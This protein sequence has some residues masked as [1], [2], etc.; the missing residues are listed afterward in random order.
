MA[1]ENIPESYMKNQESIPD[2]F[3]YDFKMTEDIIKTKVNLNR[4][5]FSFLQTGKKQVHFADTSVLV[6][7]SQS[8]LLKKGNCLWSELLDTEETY[9]CKLFFFSEKRLKEF[10]QKHIKENQEHKEAISYFVIE[11]DSYFDSYL[12]SLSTIMDAPVGFMDTL[13]TVKFEEL[14]LYLINKYGVKFENYL[15][16]LITEE[17][18]P[19]KK[20]V[21]KNVYT[22]LTLEEI[23]F[24]CNMS[25][26]TFKRHFI[27]EFEVSPGRW[28]RDKRLLKAKELILREGLKSSEVYFDL[29]YNNLSN[30]SS[31]FKNKFGVNP[32]EI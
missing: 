14:L 30:F 18:S 8:L 29:G 31:A 19:L 21:E 20:V 4:H 3:V 7:N 5:I 15:L 25:L 27:K 16:S 32:S 13:L 6:D 22:S 9:Y 11:N 28:F 17:K 26:S 12:N 10:I 1:I 24:L 2:L 23:A